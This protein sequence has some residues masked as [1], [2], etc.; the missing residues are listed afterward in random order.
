MRIFVV[1]IIS[2]FSIINLKSQS[3]VFFFFF[4]LSNKAKIINGKDKL[5]E[6]LLN[7][8]NFPNHMVFVPQ[9]TVL[10]GCIEVLPNGEFNR[11]FSLN[12]IDNLF[13]AEFESLVRKSK[14]TWANNND[15]NYLVIPIEFRNTPVEAY[16]TDYGFMPDYFEDPIVCLAEYDLEITSDLDLVYRFENLLKQRKLSKAL[17]VLETIINRKPFKEVYYVKK[18]RLL[19]Y[20]DELE[21]AAV[22]ERKVEIMFR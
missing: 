11:V 19:T 13:L 21:K 12:A 1:L 16:V 15:T 22:D 2:L 9:V 14:V 8:L 4:Q 18:I 5:Y 17:K 10:I 7:D 3:T 20:L 6:A